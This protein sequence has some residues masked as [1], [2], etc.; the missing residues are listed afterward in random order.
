MCTG[1]LGRGQTFTGWVPATGFNC[2]GAA[3]LNGEDPDGNE[4]PWTLVGGTSPS[5]ALGCD[6]D[7]D[8][9]DWFYPHVGLFVRS[10]GH[11]DIIDPETRTAHYLGV[12]GSGSELELDMSGSGAGVDD[13]E[14]LYGLAE[15]TAIDCTDDVCPFFL[16]N[17]S[18]YNAADSWDVR[19]DTSAG[20]LNKSISD[21]QIDLL[22]STLGVQ[23]MALSTVAFAPG[24]IRLLV[25]FTV[26]S[27]GMCDHTGDG[28]HVLI[29]ENDDYVFAD[30]NAGALEIEHV[31]SV[32]GIGW[33]TLTI[34]VVPDEEPPEAQ[35]DLASTED[36]DD[37]DG[38]VLDSTRSLST[39]PDDDIVEELWWV[40][41]YPC[42]H[43]CVAPVGYRT[44][45]LEATD[46][47]GAVHR[48]P[49]VAIAVQTAS[50]CIP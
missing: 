46:A 50:A 35:H 42:S 10:P 7:A 32:Q 21:V 18:A 29:V 4:I 16:A 34:S 1:G 47:R 41:G 3:H 15:Y 6:L 25:E 30:Y 49:E 31:F 48:T 36:C 40:D 22:Q 38:L 24:S 14:P 44:I 5:P 39:D 19:I 37:P 28:T 12:E 9:V 20:K 23:N 26:S 8:C 11:A 27:C 33:A 13:T 17:L 45:S 2:I 43:G